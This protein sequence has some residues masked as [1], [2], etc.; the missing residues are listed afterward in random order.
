MD[1]G[2]PTVTFEKSEWYKVKTVLLLKVVI[3]VTQVEQNPKK[4][5]TGLR[6]LIPG[7]TH[8]GTVFS[9]IDNQSVSWK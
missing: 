1:T 8:P 6:M 5:V 9:A 3:T 4:D 7:I 2:G